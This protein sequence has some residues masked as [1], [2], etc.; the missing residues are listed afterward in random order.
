MPGS[1]IGGLKAARTNKLRYGEDFYKRMG[2]KGG[3]KGTTGGFWYAK[4][5][6]GSNLPQEAGRLGGLKS[7]KPKKEQEEPQHSSWFERLRKAI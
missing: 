2:Q 3:R 7:R 4:Y 5:V 6:L 1:K